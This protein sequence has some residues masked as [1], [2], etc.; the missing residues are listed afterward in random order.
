MR[1]EGASEFDKRYR[2]WRDKGLGPS[3]ARCVATARTVRRMMG[4]HYDQR[5][6]FL[7]P[8]RLLG[9]IVL[10]V[11]ALSLFAMG[12]LLADALLVAVAAFQLSRHS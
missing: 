8:A 2:Y 10:L 11:A 7:R 6:S 1:E 4:A 5:T 12:Q 3:A 9:G